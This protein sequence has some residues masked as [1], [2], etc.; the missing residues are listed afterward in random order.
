VAKRSE[1]RPAV[2]DRRSGSEA[3]SRL[4]ARRSRRQ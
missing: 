4:T 2:R 3:G 1:A